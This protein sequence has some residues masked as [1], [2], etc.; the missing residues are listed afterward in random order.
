MTPLGGSAGG[1]VQIEVIR[2]GTGACATR[3]EARRFTLEI[4]FVWISVP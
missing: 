1:T 2:T 3:K 4:G